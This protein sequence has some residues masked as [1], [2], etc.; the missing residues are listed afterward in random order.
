[1]PPKTSTGSSSAGVSSAAN[2]TGTDLTKSTFQTESG[3]GLTGEQTGSPGFFF[4]I[5]TVNTVIDSKDFE[6]FGIK[7]IPNSSSDYFYHVQS[8]IHLSCQISNTQNVII[9]NAVQKCRES[10]KGL[11]LLSCHVVGCVLIADCSKKTVKR[12]ANILDY[13]RNTNRTRI[14]TSV[15]S[16]HEKIIRVFSFSQFSIV[17][18]KNDI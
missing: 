5:I 8:C 3:A 10:I 6:I 14:R 1:M 17:E 18:I 15:F 11:V 4:K 7:Y 12:D 9:Q 2:S 13:P 16:L